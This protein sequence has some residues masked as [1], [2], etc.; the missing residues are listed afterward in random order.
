[1][2]DPDRL[3]KAIAERETLFMRSLLDVE[4]DSAHG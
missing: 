2:K 4:E 3:M 1:M